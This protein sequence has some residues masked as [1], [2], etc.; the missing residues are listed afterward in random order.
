LQAALERFVGG[1]SRVPLLGWLSGRGAEI[2]VGV[3]RYYT[4][5]ERMAGS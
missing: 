5:I 3:Q 1:T 4:Y 2:L